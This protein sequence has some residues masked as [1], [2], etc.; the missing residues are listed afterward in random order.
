MGLIQT[1]HFDNLDK[2]IADWM[3]YSK[4]P[5]LKEAEIFEWYD[6]KNLFKFILGDDFDRFNNIVKSTQRDKKLSLIIEK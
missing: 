4:S 2:K 5:K 3:L 6:N 1:K